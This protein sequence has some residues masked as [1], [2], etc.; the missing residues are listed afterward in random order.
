MSETQF[1]TDDFLKLL[2]D[3]LRAGP[4]SPQWHE[5]VTRLRRDNAVETDEYRLLVRAREDLESGRDYRSVRAGPEFTRKVMRGI[6][7]EA[8]GS[9]GGMQSTTLITLLAAVGIAGVIVIIAVILLRGGET[10]TARDLAATAFT[11]TAISSD[12]SREVPVEWRP[13][14]AEPVVSDMDR[15]LRGAPASQGGEEYQVGGIVS[16]MSYA[17]AQAL[18]I[19]ASMR[20]ER[21]TSQAILRLF[22]AEEAPPVSAA[23]AATT[24]TAS[25]S[26]EFVAELNNGTVTAFQPDGSLA[27]GPVK[28]SPDDGQLIHLTIK[29]DRQFAVVEVDGKQ[30]FGG[31]HGLS[32]DK[33]RWPGLRFLIRGPARAA[34][35]ITVQSIRILKP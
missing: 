13:F 5:A 10:P 24:T 18:A 6:D 2:T 30:V 15:G 32:P 17:P 31:E 8:A 26:R 7:G 1:E 21:P 3:A 35:D 28:V 11:N 34:D 4:G 33:P 23:A 29:M 27:G 9:T 19:E 22:V 16:A 12:L 25:P 20:M 14:G